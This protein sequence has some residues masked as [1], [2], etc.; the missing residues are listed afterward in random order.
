MVEAAANAPELLELFGST[1]P[2]A[3]PP[4]LQGQYSPFYGPAHRR[5]RKQCRDFVERELLP[6]VE[7]WEEAGGFQ[8]EELREKAYA[9]GIY[10]ALWPAEYGGTPPEGSLGSWQGVDPF[11]DFI[12]NDELAR[13]GSGGVLAALFGGS[14]IGLPPVLAHGSD[15]LKEKVA[16]EVIAGRKTTCLCITEPG[17]GSDVAAVRTTAKREEDCWVINGSKKWI[18]GGMSADFFTVL[19]R[20][21][22]SSAGYGGMSLVVVEKGMPGLKLTRMRTQGW[23]SSQ[24]TFVEFDDVRVPLGNLIGMEGMGFLYTMVNFNHERFLM[25]VQMLRNCRICVEEAVSFAR[26][27]KTFGKSLINHQVIRFKV[28][29]MARGIEGIQRQIES[30]CYQVKCGCPDDRLA[31]S[32]A[33]LKVTSSR[34]LE[35]CAREASQIFGGQSF[36]RSGPGGRVERIYREVRVMAIGGGSEEIMMELAMRQAKL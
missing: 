36:T 5:W 7:E 35:L 25:C 23:W 10:G 29:D 1:V 28:A 21:D 16:R 9:A 22:T 17:G 3:E 26:R 2:F 4:D 6:H 19:C 15:E 18:T 8:T 14:G 11:F 34:H 27:R 12:L 24:T 13:C 33:M 32:I 31:A 20:T 30:Y